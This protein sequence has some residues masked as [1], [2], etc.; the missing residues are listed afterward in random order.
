M[1]KETTFKIHSQIFQDKKLA[2]Q[3]LKVKSERFNVVIEDVYKET[4][5]YEY[6]D[7]DGISD[8]HFYT[9]F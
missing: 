4:Y 8:W 6:P 7:I 5:N 3:Y 9:N 1:N 2:D